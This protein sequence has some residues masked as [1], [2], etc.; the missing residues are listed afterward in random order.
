MKTFSM[1]LEAD[2]PIPRR[3]GIEALPSADPEREQIPLDK[4]LAYLRKMAQKAATQRGTK[5]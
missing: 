4:W 3:L 1:G 2:A 5:G